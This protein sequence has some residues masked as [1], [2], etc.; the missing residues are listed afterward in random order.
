MG[1]RDSS[2]GSGGGSGGNFERYRQ[3][4]ICVCVIIVPRSG[5]G[6]EYCFL[7]HFLF[8]SIT[9]S[10]DG[11]ACN[12]RAQIFKSGFKMDDTHLMMVAVSGGHRLAFGVTESGDNGGKNLLRPCLGV[13]DR[14]T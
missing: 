13:P 6:T 1:R 2:L 12:H 4:A 14:D 11:T 3:S 5:E 7:L 10:V 9:N 8:T